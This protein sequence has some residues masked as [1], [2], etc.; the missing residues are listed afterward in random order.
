MP[1]ITSELPAVLRERLGLVRAVETGTFRGDGAARLAA[2]FDHVV[3]VELSEQLHAAAVEW[4]RPLQNVRAVQG[5]SVERLRDL[6]DP[7]APTFWFLDG[8]WS[9]GHTAG[10]G[11]ECPVLQEL[12]IIAGGHPDDVVVVDDARYFT[13]AP[14][15]PHDPLQWPTLLQVVDAL[16]SAHPD[17]HITLLDDQVLAVPARAK[18]DIDAYGQRMTATPPPTPLNRARDLALAGGSVLKRRLRR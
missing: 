18:S 5:H 11:D 9:G 3:T 7:A 13:A 15:P 14:P 16:R 1:S 4:L 17:H 8:H 6:V 2:V 10:S 12:E